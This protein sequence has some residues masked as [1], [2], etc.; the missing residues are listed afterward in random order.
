MGNKL[1]RAANIGMFLAVV[2]LSFVPARAGEAAALQVDEKEHR[3]TLAGKAAKQNIYDVLKGAIEY[4]AVMPGGKEYESLFVCPVEPQ[5]LY[6]ALTRV[7]LRAGEPASYAGGDFTPP[8]GG[9]LRIFV[10]WNDGKEKQHKP[11]EYFVHD[12]GVAEPRAAKPME[13]LD[14]MFTGSVKVNDPDSGKS[15]LQANITK[16]L[17]SLHQKDG[18]VLI[19]NPVKDANAENRYHTNM[20]LFL[21]E[22]TPVTLIFEPLIAVKVP[23]TQRIHFEI[24]GRVQGVGFREFIQR[25]AKSLAVT[26]WARNLASGTVEVAAEGKEA[27]V[28]EFQEKLKKG[29]RGSQV[30][31]TKALPVDDAEVYDAE[32]EV[33]ESK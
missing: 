30:D 15:V 14:W 9:K 13:Q 12:Y 17:I 27:A 21:K 7:G 10:E 23:G 33:R 22:G 31:G 1:L 28:K 29:P 8:K 3:V 5:A 4:V 20:A 6:N 16:S 24:S 26:G 2:C 11:V 25:T 32:F 19:Q 18:T